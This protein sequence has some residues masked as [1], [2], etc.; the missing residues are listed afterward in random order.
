MSAETKDEQVGNR[1]AGKLRVRFFN[2]AL[3]NG[4]VMST[5]AYEEKQTFMANLI[6][7]LET[8]NPEFAWIQFLFLRT[9]Y[10]AGLVRLKN[11]IHRTKTAIEQPSMDL[12]S[13]QE[14]DRK[15]LYRDYYRRAEARMKK[16]DEVVTQP[17]ITVAIQ[18]MW[19][20]GERDSINALP[21]DHCTDE[22]DC[23]AL[24]QYKDPRM[25]LELLD[26]SMVEDIS[27]YLDGYTKSRVEPPSFMVTPEELPSYVHLP[28]GERVGSLASLTWGTFTRGLTRGTVGGGAG[29]SG[30]RDDIATTLVRLARVPK[31]E[32]VLEDSGVQP[33]AHLASGTVRSFE[34]IYSEGKTDLALSARTVE[35]MRGY[36]DLFDTVYGQLKYERIDP[37]PG[38]L[39]RLPEIVG[40][41]HPAL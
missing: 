7:A 9:N 17:T 34:I 13:G 31:V 15:E 16:I 5:P 11:S 32:K 29:N 28:A 26:R 22:H 27:E 35:D 40:L 18:G 39:R 2:V 1:K 20:G 36:V 19:A 3:K 37:L 6:R 8:S 25:L 14:H 41:T 12:V 30:A 23:L 21:F 33:L 24:F 38:Y 10:S 4:I